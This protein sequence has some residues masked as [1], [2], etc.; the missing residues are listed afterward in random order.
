VGEGVGHKHFVTQEEIARIAEKIGF[1]FEGCYA[2]PLP[3]FAHRLFTHNK[4][5]TVCRKA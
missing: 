4:W 5:V 1:L 2:S 3:R